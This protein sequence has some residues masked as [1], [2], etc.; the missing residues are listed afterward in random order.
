MSEK[1]VGDLDIRGN[2][3]LISAAWL[4]DGRLSDG[5]IYGCPN[6]VAVS[7]ATKTRRSPD[8]RTHLK[9]E[10]E[11]SSSSLGILPPDTFVGISLANAC[12]RIA[13]CG[14]AVPDRSRQFLADDLLDLD[15]SAPDVEVDQGELEELV[16]NF[17]SSDC[18]S[19][20][21]SMDNDGKGTYA[22]RNS[23]LESTLKA[24]HLL[25]TPMAV[26]QRE[27]AAGR[28]AM[29]RITDTVYKR[30]PLEDV[31]LTSAAPG[32]Q[33]PE[34]PSCESP[35]PESS[36][37]FEVSVSSPE[38]H[39]AASTE[40]FICDNAAKLALM[41][42][43]ERRFNLEKQNATFES[44]CDIDLSQKRS[45]STSISA[46]FRA[47]SAP[48]GRTFNS[49]ETLS[50]AIDF[51]SRQL[52]SLPNEDSKDNKK[53]RDRSV[54][55]R[56][57]VDR[58]APEGSPGNLENNLECLSL[59]PVLKREKLPSGK[60]GL[61]VKS[62]NNV[63]DSELKEEQGTMAM[64]TLLSGVDLSSKL[65][66]SPWARNL[67]ESTGPNSASVLAEWILK[68]NKSLMA[69]LNESTGTPSEQKAKSARHD[70]KEQTKSFDVKHTIHGF[71][72][73][74][75]GRS[76]RSLTSSIALLEAG[77]QCLSFGCLHLGEKAYCSVPL[78]CREECGYVR[79][80]VVLRRASESFKIEG[81]ESGCLLLFNAGETLKLTASFCP[82]SVGFHYGK[83]VFVI[84]STGQQFKIC[85]N[86]WGGRANVCM[87]DGG[88]GCLFGSRRNWCL[89]LLLLKADRFVGTFCV[90]NSGQLPAFVKV[91]PFRD[92]Q[93]R[94]PMDSHRIAIEPSK[95]ILLP[96]QQEKTNVVLT[97]AKDSNA[98]SI[99]LAVF[100]GEE[101]LRRNLRAA[102]T[103]KA[104]VYYIHGV[105]FGEFFDGED[106]C[107]ISAPHF[108]RCDEGGLF[109]VGL[110][111]FAMR[112]V[113][114]ISELDTIVS[115]A[116]MEIN[117]TDFP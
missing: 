50:P 78:R 89:K 80:R 76:I 73:T 109:N 11:D 82:Q 30:K 85:L 60:S 79:C 69:K 96:A 104:R 108:T 21:E 83:I 59:T 1:L 115:F 67:F 77:K 46:F 40:E 22:Q 49:E 47:K 24:G 5:S 32:L 53:K 95:F 94:E 43:A 13:S 75:D 88:S 9:P 90:R 23:G 6:P 31:Q 17:D 39:T 91:V 113:P 36:S 33:M 57:D 71:H 26:L 117:E 35:P 111:V 7:S 72:S 55:A 8:S 81:M 99:F 97:T 18:I 15:I 2:D 51:S 38:R 28:N 45:N 44:N 116:P 112:V 93:L 64:T 42:E 4:A 27:N 106:R 68:S 54:E 86:G 62:E 92:S 20:D 107:Q 87:N 98:E 110:Q 16:A 74:T 34:L 10:R 48:L 25:H 41:E 114:E 19:N 58:N 103:R 101:V 61:S 14:N 66:L 3:S 105:N 65:E 56:R 63:Q 84:E 12:N 100:W 29:V 52:N 37:M 70:S 102:Q